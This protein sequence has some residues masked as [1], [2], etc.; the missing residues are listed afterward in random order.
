MKNKDGGEGGGLINFCPLKS[1]RLFEREAQKRIYGNLIIVCNTLKKEG[2]AFRN[3]SKKYKFPTVMLAR[4][5]LLLSVTYIL[6][7]I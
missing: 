1:G 6:E 2:R 7:V 4:V 3:S 5:L